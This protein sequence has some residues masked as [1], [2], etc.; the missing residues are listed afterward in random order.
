MDPVYYLNVSKTVLIPTCRG[1]QQEVGYK[2]VELR[3]KGRPRSEQ[4][5]LKMLLV[6]G[7]TLRR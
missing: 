7:A 6:A 3:E 2:A 4:K 1:R 5:Q